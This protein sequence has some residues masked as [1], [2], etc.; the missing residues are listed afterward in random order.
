MGS[1]MIHEVITAASGFG[2]FGLI[3][4]LLNR[5][6]PHNFGCQQIFL[7]V[8]NPLAVSETVLLHF[9]QYDGYT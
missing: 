9:C 4:F 6:I 8:Y 2:S 1:T 3:C 7:H 5:L